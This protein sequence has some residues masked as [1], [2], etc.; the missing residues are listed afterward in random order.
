[1][2][3]RGIA[4]TLLY[5]CVP[6]DDM[7]RTALICLLAFAILLI[8]LIAGCTS[9]VEGPASCRS[10]ADCAQ[11][12]YCKEK[13]CADFAPDTSCSSDEDCTLLNSE[14]RLGCCWQ[15]AC[16][17]VD[18]SQPSWVAVS[19]LWFAAESAKGCPLREECG[20]APMCAVRVTDA[21][22]E[23]RCVDGACAKL[24]I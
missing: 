1:M 3:G 5:C 22:Y 4:E 19:R 12:E 2:P 23:P 13:A 9:P 11:A 10:D 6:A 8:V 16:D 20:P 14:Y 17:P 21:A 15:G 24:P 7:A 18:Y